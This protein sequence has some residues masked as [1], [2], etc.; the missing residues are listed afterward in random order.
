MVV[1]SGS[2]SLESDRNKAIYISWL[3]CTRYPL[4]VRKINSPSTCYLAFPP[5]ECIQDL[6]F[7]YFCHLLQHE[8][9]HKNLVAQNKK[10]VLFFM[11]LGGLTGWFLL[12]SLMESQLGTSP[13]GNP[14]LLASVPTWPF[15][16]APLRRSGP[17]AGLQTCKGKSCKASSGAGSAGDTHAFQHIPLVRASHGA[18]LGFLSFFFFS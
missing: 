8:K 3:V 5:S 2:R 12:G 16:W 7:I 15:I 18:R 10:D 1:W 9:Q 11:I 17:R 4:N 13:S 6:D 14:G